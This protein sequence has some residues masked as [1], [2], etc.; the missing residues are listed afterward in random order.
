MEPELKFL[1]AGKRDIVE[2][3]VAN[4][5]AAKFKVHPNPFHPTTFCGRLL[6]TF[7]RICPGMCCN[8]SRT[9]LHTFQ[10]DSPGNRVRDASRVTIRDDFADFVRN[11][12]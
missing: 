6:D 11:E 5:E 7:E 1:F 12:M 2:A 4:P 3:V 10:E 9:D 8:Q